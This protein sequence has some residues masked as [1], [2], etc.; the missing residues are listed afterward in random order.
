MRGSR[1]QT[2]SGSRSSVASSIT[3]HSSRAHSSRPRLAQPA[4]QLV[5]E[6]VEVLDVLAGVAELLRA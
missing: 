4:L 1:R 5:G 6:R 3:R 2:S